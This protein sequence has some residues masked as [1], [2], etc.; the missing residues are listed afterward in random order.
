MQYSHM[1]G[2]IWERNEVPSGG[3]ES[4]KQ[5]LKSELPKKNQ[6]GEWLEPLLSGFQ[7]EGLA[8]YAQKNN[9]Y[10]R[11]K[12]INNRTPF[13][14]TIT[15]HTRDFK[16]CCAP[17]HACAARQ[18]THV[19]RGFNPWE[20]SHTPII[21]LHT[22]H[23]VAAQFGVT[24]SETKMCVCGASIVFTQRRERDPMFSFCK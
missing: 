19:W 5:R 4:Q 20:K 10:K 15:P 6:A 24:V 8:F 3:A 13:L 9:I 21:A 12:I 18:V 1:Q 14:N 11:K 17:V 7:V 22:H 16:L 23:W 2:M